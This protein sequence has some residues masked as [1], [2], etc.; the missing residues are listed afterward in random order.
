MNSL[1]F[2]LVAFLLCLGITSSQQLRAEEL[3][4]AVVTTISPLYSLLSALTKGVVEVKLLIPPKASPHAFQL[5]PGV[6]KALN[7]ADV[8]VWIGPTMETTLAS[9]MKK[10]SYQSKILTVL[11]MPGITSYGKRCHSCGHDEDHNDPHVWLDVNNA[12]VIVMAVQRRLI[13]KF[14]ALKVALTAN[15]K[16]LIQRLDD[17]DQELAHRFKG[18]SNVPFAVF[19]DGY[20]YFEKAYKLS[21]P[22]V[23]HLIPGHHSF[24][25]VKKRQALLE[26]LRNKK[27]QCIFTEPQF[28]KDLP[29]RLAQELGMRMIEI[30]PLGDISTSYVVMMQKLGHTLS[31]CLQAQ[32]H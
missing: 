32:Q 28:S 9:L 10:Q 20:Q 31:K 18:L 25:S 16:R 23:L 12:K 2:T 14:P 11:E 30:D 6:I 1:K 29:K 24:L 26:T 21:Q 3:K 4:P 15:G 5:R 27:V 19:H 7:A 13:E 22:V 8:V 17:L